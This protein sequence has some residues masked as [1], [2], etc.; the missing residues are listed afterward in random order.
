MVPKLESA[1][2][3]LK[4]DTM[5]YSRLL[6]MRS[7]GTTS[8]INRNTVEN[9]TKYGSLF[10]HFQEICLKNFDTEEFYG[11]RESFNFNSTTVNKDTFE[12]LKASGKVFLVS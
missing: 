4:L 8:S 2:L 5:E 7:F 6:I 9:R 10:I 1:L 11:P 3:K 12:I